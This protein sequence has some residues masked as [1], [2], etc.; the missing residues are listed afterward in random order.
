MSKT[1]IFA[2]VG[3]PILHSKSPEMHNAAFK[4]L[5]IDAVYTR[6]AA[7]SAEE[8]LETAKAIGIDGLNITSPFKEDF[9]KLVTLDETVKKLGAVN[10]VLLRQNKSVGY[11]TDPKGVV[12]ALKSRGISLAGKK[13]VVL[14]GGGAAKAAALGLISVGA[15]VTIANRTIEKAKSIADSLGCEHARLSDLAR[16]MKNVNILVSAV[17]TTERIILPELL[18]KNLVVL[19]ANYSTET[20]LVSDAKNKGCRTI[21]GRE[22]LLH[23]GAAAFELFTGKKAPLRVMRKAIYTK[24]DDKR[25]LNIALIGM[26]GS[27][28]NTVAKEIARM[29]KI[30]LID[31]DREI[32]KQAR[33]SIREIFEEDG[34][35][36]FRKMECAKIAKIKNV[37]SSI[38]ACGGGVV[39][40]NENVRTL[41]DRC[42]VVWLWASPEV[43]HRRT[44]NDESRPL[45]NIPNR[46]EVLFRI[47]RAR[48]ATYASAADLVIT[49][50][51][52]TPEKTAKRIL[53]E[54]NAV[55]N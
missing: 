23:Q 27:G 47:L 45:L 8:A 48:A 28:K 50:D 35:E 12:G 6:L 17:S 31:V 4:A 16:I 19:D 3:K 7:E 22:W 30:K 37:R 13:A 29:R 52:S 54:N 55:K 10:T 2:V 39:L 18:H 34:E 14:G 21:D 53:Y 1:K 20:A 32:E 49:T 9:A 51:K 36:E 26:M 24:K 5:G 41:K 15:S 40:N 42:T 11:N 25:K 33:K 43:M 44:K 46:Q 38:I